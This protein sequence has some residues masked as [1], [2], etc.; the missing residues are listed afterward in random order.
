MSGYL[1]YL[2]EIFYLIGRDCANIYV[3][4]GIYKDING[5][6][7]FGK[8]DLLIEHKDGTFTVV[9]HKSSFNL[10]YFHGKQLPLYGMLLGRPIRNLVIHE[11]SSGG[12]Y[13]YSDVQAKIMESYSF[14]S[15]ALKGLEGDIVTKPGEHCTGCTIDC[16]GSQTDDDG[17]L[18]I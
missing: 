4:T 7:V 11:L 13:F 2:N 9:D 5:N 6:V 3:E 12:S 1:R 8:A 17:Y 18:S 14:V 16:I 15:N 10:M